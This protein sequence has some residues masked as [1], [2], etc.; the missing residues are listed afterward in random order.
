M[1]E[2]DQGQARVLGPG[3]AGELMDIPDHLLGATLPE[4]AEG[5]LGGRGVA[6]PAMVVGIE[7]PAG[8]H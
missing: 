6:V 8:V 4:I 5:F 1:A 3:D 2:E 7:H